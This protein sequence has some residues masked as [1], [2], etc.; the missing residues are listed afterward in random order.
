MNG[1]F[2]LALLVTVNGET[3]QFNL[4]QAL[5]HDDCL[6]ALTRVMSGAPQVQVL[7]QGDGYVATSALICVPEADPAAPPVRLTRRRLP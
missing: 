2:A 4:D 5:T 6:T 1:L 3:N 7:A